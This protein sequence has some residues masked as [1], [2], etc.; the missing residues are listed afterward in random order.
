MESSREPTRAADVMA[1]ARL[2][3]ALEAPA[4][5]L[6]AFALVLGVVFVV[7][8]LLGFIVGPA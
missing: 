6:I 5:R 7:S 8:A 1:A 3:A 4:V 2:R